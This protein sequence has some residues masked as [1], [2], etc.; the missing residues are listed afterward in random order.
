MTERVAQLGDDALFAQSINFGERSETLNRK[1]QISQDL[2]E[3]WVEVAIDAGKTLIDRG[4]NEPAKIEKKLLVGAPFKIDAFKID[5]HADQ[6][7]VLIALEEFS[8]A[9][10]GQIRCIER[11]LNEDKLMSPLHVQG[12]ECQAV[13]N[14][15]EPIDRLWMWAAVHDRTQS[16]PESFKEK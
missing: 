14:R 4:K 10:I 12:G 9:I 5:P 16:F 8:N 6:I 13:A 15:N 11:I 1:F 3:T 7:T 2:S